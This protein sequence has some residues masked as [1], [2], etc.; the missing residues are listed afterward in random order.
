M[1][2]SM[3]NMAS[4]WMLKNRE[5]EFQEMAEFTKTFRE[6][7]VALESVSDKIAKDRFGE[8]IAVFV[9]FV[10]F[11]ILSVA[12]FLKVQKEKKNIFN[13][14]FNFTSF[15][16]LLALLLQSRTCGVDHK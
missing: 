9:L 12:H 8:D 15:A 1:S 6:K 2:D 4:S 14:F 3:R 7:M 5:P 11:A 13:T 16:R 10:Y